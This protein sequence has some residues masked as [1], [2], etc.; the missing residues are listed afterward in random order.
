[1]SDLIK[2]GQDEPSS[3]GE[4]TNFSQFSKIFGDFIKAK[5]KTEEH[6]HKPFEWYSTLWG[7]LGGIVLSSFFWLW[8]LHPDL[9]KNDYILIGLG[10]MLGVLLTL[11]AERIWKKIKK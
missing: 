8:I 4:L 5:T 7:F 1:M 3:S 11:M 9:C 2:K 6:K 10:V